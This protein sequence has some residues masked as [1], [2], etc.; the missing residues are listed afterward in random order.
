[1]KKYQI[2]YADPPWKT[3]TF[4]QRKDGWLSRDLEYPTM[5][6]TEIC[7]LPVKTLIDE[8]AILFLWCVE[9]EIP[10]VAELMLAWGFTFKQVGFVWHKKAKTT[11]GQN[12]TFGS[13]TRRS[14]ELCFLGTRGKYLVKS[15]AVEQFISEPKRRHSQK[16]DEIRSR[17]VK[18][19]GDIPRLELFARQKTEGWDVWGNEVESDI[20]IFSHSSQ[21]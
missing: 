18:L 15:R 13:Y 21:P 12:S 1:V 2:I 7:E 8:D 11:D 17:I 14:T 10:R 5:T 9:S 19:V 4:K 16:P 6:F 3:K 20:N